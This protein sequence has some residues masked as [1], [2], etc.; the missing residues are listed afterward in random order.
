MED[1]HGCNERS[2]EVAERE[3]LFPNLGT[4]D[5]YPPP[6]TLTSTSITGWMTCA[7]CWAHDN[8]EHLVKP[9][10][11]HF[12]IGTSVHHAAELV[13]NLVLDD[14]PPI[15]ST[16]GAILESALDVFDRE[17][18]KESDRNGT[19]RYPPTE[20]EAADAKITA[21]RVVRFA[22]PHLYQIY[23]QR[24]LVT[25][26]YQLPAHLNPFPFPMTGRCDAISGGSKKGLPLVLS[27]IKTAAQRRRPDLNNRIQGAVYAL[28]VRESGEEPRVIFDTIT[29]T[30]SPTFNS[31]GLG[32]EGAEYMTTSQLMVTKE[33]VIDVAT[34]ISEGWKAYLNEDWDSYRRHFPIGQGW[35][36]L[37]DYD[38]GVAEAHLLAA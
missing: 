24:G 23:R 32:P 14:V 36:G 1:T 4:P 13:G 21:S 31:Y 25:L 9:A 29:K 2:L 35:S 17:I 12:A 22:I 15:S 5:G 18:T 30:L 19:E 11:V 38:H 26:E 7:R 16:D 34:A 37:H 10:S 27:D 6:G 3:W 33:I 28:F 20:A 8:V